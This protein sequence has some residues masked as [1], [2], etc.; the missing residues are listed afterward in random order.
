MPSAQTPREMLRVGRIRDPPAGLSWAVPL[1]RAVEPDVPSLRPRGAV[2]LQ[3]QPGPVAP[4]VPVHMAVCARVD[5]SPPLHLAVCIR[6]VPDS[7]LLGLWPLL[8][9]LHPLAWGQPLT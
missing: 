3:K 7:Q 9:A 8:V 4:P 6:D 5:H 1:R 2:I